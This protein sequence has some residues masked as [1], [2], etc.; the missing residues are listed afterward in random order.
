[1]YVCMH[2]CMYACMHV[3]MYVCMYVC[4][5]VCMYLCMYVRIIRG[6]PSSC[7]LRIKDEV[8]SGPHL[9]DQKWIILR[10]VHLLGGGGGMFAAVCSLRSLRRGPE[11]L[12]AALSLNS[13]GVEGLGL[14]RLEFRI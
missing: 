2:V 6:V 13:T 12:A 14:I 4:M 1:M 3:C 8:S 5:T 9:A 11:V 7:I 10:G